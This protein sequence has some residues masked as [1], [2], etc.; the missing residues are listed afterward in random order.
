MTLPDQPLPPAAPA[1]PF[2][3]VS[4][5][6][7]AL[8][9]LAAIAI[10]AALYLGRAFFVPLLIGILASYAL[11]PM[12]NGLQYCHI[13]RSIA[14]AL[15]M[16][17]LVGG[18]SWIAYSLADEATAMIEKLPDTVRKLRKTISAERS[19]VP[20]AIQSVQEA[21]NELQAVAADVARKPGT[22]PVR[23]QPT[24]STSW[25]R[26]Y[27]LT[28]T[29]L[30]VWVAAQAPIVLL[31]AYFLL[32]SGDHFRRKLVHVVGPELSRKKDVLRI[33]GEID[34]QVQRYL[35]VTIASNA[36]IAVCTWLAF[37]AMGVEQA[38]IWGVSAG[39]LH[40]I[41]YLG[42][43][44]VAVAAGIAGF[45]QFGALLP[46]LG[47]AA[48]IMLVSGLI[49]LLFATWLQSRLARVNAAVLFIALLFFGWMWG[50]AG[51]LLGAPLIAIIKVICD[52]VES[53]KPV[54]EL[55][56]K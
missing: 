41:P 5:I 11:R 45:M 4:R 13:P 16:A 26:D 3:H 23:A 24:D 46:A 44:L 6:S 47:V 19:A 8:I 7:L 56:G 48:V 50:I 30:L 38:G 40:F 20:T 18:T 25:L 49:G 54:G 17:A 34:L 52:R 53:L 14:A 33:L 39:V 22:R 2:H 12:V 15:V 21:A 31:L 42:T 37:E 28:Q 10:I 32:A 9:I 35:F 1:D 43:V 36:L 51:L 27:A 55:L 29:A